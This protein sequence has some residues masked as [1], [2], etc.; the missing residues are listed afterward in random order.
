MPKGGTALLCFEGASA[1]TVAGPLEVFE[2]AVGCQ[3]NRGRPTRPLTVTM[4]TPDGEPAL[5]DGC[6]TIQPAG[7]LNAVSK[8]DLVLLAGMSA[9]NLDQTLRDQERLMRD[10]AALHRGGTAVAAVCSSQALLAAAG[11][12]NGRNAAIHWSRIDEFRQRWPEVQ[13]SAD[14]MVVQSD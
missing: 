4:V 10:L 5:C 14:R 6:M 13:W 2:Y 12:L 3:Q 8:P 1:S 9:H 11:L 7:A